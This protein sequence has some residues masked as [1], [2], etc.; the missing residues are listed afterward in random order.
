MRM[1]NW[2][3]YTAAVFIFILLGTVS[4]YASVVDISILTGNNALITKKY[5]NCI[6]ITS[7]NLMTP[8]D[9]LILTPSSS[10]YDIDGTRISI[11]NLKFPC[12]ARIKYHTREQEPDAELIRMD[13]L[14]YAEKTSNKFTSGDPCIQLPE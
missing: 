5:K 10:I 11:K 13:V 3:K 9:C 2:K 6:E 8:S 4:V 1:K 7:H 14:E 12:A